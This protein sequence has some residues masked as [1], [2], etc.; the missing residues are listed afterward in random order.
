[1]EFPVVNSRRN[2]IP[3]PSNTKVNENNTKDVT[4]FE[5]IDVYKGFGPIL[6]IKISKHIII[7][8]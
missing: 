8:Y 6:Y 4:T 3:K 1:M 7:V 5:H 2:V